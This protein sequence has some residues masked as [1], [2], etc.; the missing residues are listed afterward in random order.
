MQDC[1]TTNL[2]KFIN[3]PVWAVVWMLDLVVGVGFCVNSGSR[4]AGFD[5]LFSIKRRE[6][7]KAS[8]ASAIKRIF[9]LMYVHIIYVYT[10]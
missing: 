7:A 10:G 8:M 9:D 4:T 5:D 3:V 6:T 1:G 2:R